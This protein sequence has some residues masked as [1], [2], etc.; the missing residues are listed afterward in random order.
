MRI[1]HPVIHEMMRLTTGRCRW[2][3]F[4]FVA[5]KRK[6]SDCEA[7]IFF[8]RC[9]TDK[10]VSAE[11]GRREA[12]MQHL[13]QILPCIAF[14]EVLLEKE[15]EHDKALAKYE[16]WC[17]LK[18]RKM[19]KIIP[20]AMKFPGLYKKTPAIM[21]KLLDSTFG[22]AA[23]FKYRE[24][25]IANGFVVDMMVCPYVVTCAKYGCPEIVQF[26]CKSDDITCGN[27]HPKLVWG[28]TKTLGMGGA[29]CDFKLSV[30]E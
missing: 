9:N 27:M 19:A 4:L 16:E 21:R 7:G 24:K 5:R 8:S 11:Q 12:V 2:W 29:C 3:V 15:G 23:G 13:K 14:Y 10:I 20:I 28:R 18:I 17:F 26:F 25:E 22:E 6:E 30:K 1:L